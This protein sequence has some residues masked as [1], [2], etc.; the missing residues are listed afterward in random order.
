MRFLGK[1]AAWV[2]SGAVMSAQVAVK[3]ADALKAEAAQAQGLMDK[4]NY[5][6]A[7]PLCEDLHA[8]A[9]QNPYYTERLAMALLGQV[10]TQ[11][12][13]GA[14]ATRARAKQLLLEA[15]SEGDNSNLVQILLE[16]MSQGEQAGQNAPPAGQEWVDQGE[17]AFG[18][19]DLTGALGFYKKAL[20]V[21][22]KN[23]GAALFAGDAE[24]KSGHY[25]EAGVWFAQAI[26][27]D[28]DKE[29]AY[30]YWGDALE[31]NGEHKRAEEEFIA[32]IV[33]Q[34]YQRAPRLGL[35]QWADKNHATVLPPQVKLP[36]R[37]V[38]TPREG[39]GINFTMT[40][41]AKDD[42]EGPLATTY[43]VGAAIWQGG[44]FQKQFPQEKTYRH[45]L[46]EEA[47]TIRVMLG[48]AKKLPPDK[49]SDSTKTLM[50]LDAAGMLECW[51]LLDHADQGIAQDYV[52]Y[53]KDHRAL[54][55]RYIAQYDVHGM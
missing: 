54:M 24:Y 37:G 14:A 17:A 52:A 12:A 33:A 31:K 44:A 43:A 38:V 16:Q 22:P 1:V 11:D 8:Q 48:A 4:Q 5:V 55:E 13:K 53:R 3:S 49:L 46:P 15:K 20:E 51:I 42:P 25:G 39:G 10:G 45:S 6:A 26:A 50:A 21:N 41:P 32:A 47:Q 7:L 23:Y 2:L 19:G 35:K 9:P 40:P 28:P 36:P 34:P 29:T 27:I 30:R 18:K